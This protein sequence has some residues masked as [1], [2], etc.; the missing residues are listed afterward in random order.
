[1]WFYL[2]EIVEKEKTLTGLQKDHE[3]AKAEGGGG[4][5]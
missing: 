4:I 2:V 5:F 1:M 3:E